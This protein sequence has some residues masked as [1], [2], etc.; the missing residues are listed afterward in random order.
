M[1]GRGEIAPVHG[2]G[3]GY[4]LAVVAAAAALGATHAVAPLLGGAFFFFVFPAVLLAAVVGGA[5]PGLACAGIYAAAAS[6]FF[7][8]PLGSLAVQET[9]TLVRLIL[10]VLSA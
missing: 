8:A 7:V 4:A 10:L 6:W 5:G 1:P 2:A 9:R 3:A